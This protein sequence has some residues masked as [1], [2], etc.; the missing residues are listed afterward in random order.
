MAGFTIDQAGDGIC[1][2]SGDLGFA[3]A[4]EIL[5][6]GGRMLSGRSDVTFDLKGVKHT[7]S[8]GLAVLLE[9]IDLGR[10]KGAAIK[11]L[12]IP[13]SLLDIAQL[14]NAESLLGLN[15]D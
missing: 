12:N 9:W 8:A 7:D 6:A 14:S 1:R 3:T 5:P 4:A 11:F 15:T 13:A 10:R 2:V